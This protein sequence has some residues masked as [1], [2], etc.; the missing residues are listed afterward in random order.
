MIT[1]KQIDADALLGSLDAIVRDLETNSVVYLVRM[2]TED[3]DLVIGGM[4]DAEGTVGFAIVPLGATLRE[5]EDVDPEYGW[6]VRV[7][8]NEVESAMDLAPGYRRHPLLHR[9]SG[10]PFAISLGLAEYEE[11][12][13]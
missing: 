2:H 10:P 4:I 7:D 3:T 13:P 9:G 12:R 5:V 6:P 8:L 1:E 11:R